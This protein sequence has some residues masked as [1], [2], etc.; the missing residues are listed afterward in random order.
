MNNL[1]SKQDLLKAFELYNV[2]IYKYIFVRV[3]RS[4]EVA[5]D[6]AQEIF[7]KAWQHRDSYDSK[8]ATVKT[9]LF[10]IARNQLTDHF[11]KN[12][13]NPLPLKDDIGEAE[14]GPDRDLLMETIFLHMKQLD[15]YDQELITLRFIEDLSI[16][17]VAKIVNK[18]YTATKISIYRALS[19][20]RNL[21]NETN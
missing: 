9:W 20:L 7:M 11:R 13:N 19:K 5:Q 4:R 6:L 2:L 16:E 12:K 21:I 15:N 8:K 18:Q 14:V 17:D 10:V 3:G 1:Q